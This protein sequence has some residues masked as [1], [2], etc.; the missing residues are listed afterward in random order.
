MNMK[1][2]LEEREK[3]LQTEAASLASLRELLKK[4]RPGTSRQSL[5]ERTFHQ[6]SRKSVGRGM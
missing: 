2:Y 4:S 1:S 3:S 5:E 6:R